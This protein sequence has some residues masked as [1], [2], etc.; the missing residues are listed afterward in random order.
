MD[1]H[2]TSFFANG[3]KDAQTEALS[4][5]APFLL[6]DQLGMQTN[7]TENYLSAKQIIETIVAQQ[8][9]E[10][11]LDQVSESDLVHAL[12]LAN[13]EILRLFPEEHPLVSVFVALPRQLEGGGYQLL[14]AGCGDI[15]L[16]SFK[17][18]KQQLV[19]CDPY[20]GQLP[21]ALSM[22]ERKT[23]MRNCLGARSPLHVS[24]S[25]IELKEGYQYFALSYG[26][27]DALAPME[28]AR[29]SHNPLEF[30][31]RLLS[32]FSSHRM[33]EHEMHAFHFTT[34]SALSAKEATSPYIANEIQL[35]RKRNHVSIISLS[36]AT[37]GLLTLLGF[38]F[39]SD[40][41]PSP[42]PLAL[43]DAP[44][45]NHIEQ[46][47]QAQLHAL[48]EDK[49]ALLIELEALKKHQEAFE[50][51]E[52]ALMRAV[53]ETAGELEALKVEKKT[54]EEQLAVATSLSS[55]EPVAEQEIPDFDRSDL[56]L[57]LAELK[58]R[59]E[60]L[61]SK[62]SSMH[63]ENALLATT[64]Q[65]LQAALSEKIRFAS[66]LE[67]EVALLKQTESER[68]TKEQQQLL[69]RDQLLQELRQQLNQQQAALKTLTESRASLTEELN[70]LKNQQS[71]LATEKMQ[72]ARNPFKRHV[73][74]AGETLSTLSEQYYGT[75]KRWQ[76]IYEA[77]KDRIS[78]PASIKVGTELIIP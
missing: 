43:P 62:E 76:D 17:D 21:K 26:A 32:L 66:T 54:L 64:V 27:C 60:E 77:N 30:S 9:R 67:S 25:R 57:A 63:S 55:E 35:M 56:E 59:L 37:L 29:P 38:H 70:R 20:T 4:S 33:Q 75:S 78:N 51:N 23:Q 58:E 7:V 28:L 13:T 5:N 34:A 15:C 22:F 52:T 11:P 71:Q 47:L 45:S 65:E 50:K 10:G 12:E 68:D 49:D 44:Q 41:S 18:G 42:S 1:L 40:N 73:V 3:F 36:A 69:Q 24:C 8:F 16:L 2:A 74:T 39:A 14:V 19:F 6:C 61:A 48:S 46:E 72:A 53:E 31:Q